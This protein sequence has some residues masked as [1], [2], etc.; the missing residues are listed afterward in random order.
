MKGYEHLFFIC[1][2]DC[3]VLKRKQ[4]SIVMMSCDE[5]D[6]YRPFGIFVLSSH[7]SNTTLSLYKE[8]SSLIQLKKR[9]IILRIKVIYV[10]F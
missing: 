5:I 9:F 7:N 4:K 6:L 1:I 2:F 10:V 8:K 3:I